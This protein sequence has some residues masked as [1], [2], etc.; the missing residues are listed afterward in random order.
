MER[1]CELSIEYRPTAV[2]NFGSVLINAVKEACDRR[3]FDPHDVF[4]SYRGGDVR[5]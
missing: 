2:Y 4:S 3:G 5:G 1:F